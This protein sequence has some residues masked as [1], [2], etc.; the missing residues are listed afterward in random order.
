MEEDFAAPRRTACGA[1]A[2][3]ERQVVEVR[4]L[5]M[6]RRPSF[7]LPP[8]GSACS[9]RRRGRPGGA[10]AKKRKRRKELAKKA[11]LCFIMEPGSRDGQLRDRPA[12]PGGD[13][14]PHSGGERTKWRL[15]LAACGPKDTADLLSRKRHPPARTRDRGGATRA[16]PVVSSLF[17]SRQTTSQKPHEKEIR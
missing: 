6:A 17:S 16:D 13:D 14:A 15:S 1:R 2:S 3:A 12:A 11:V 5:S 8:S 10:A 9:P 4:L 7:W